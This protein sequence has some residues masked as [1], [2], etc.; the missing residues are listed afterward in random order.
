MGMDVSH[1]MVKRVVPESEIKMQISED[2]WIE[3][4]DG[5]H[6]IDV[7]S[8]TID[9]MNKN[10]F[11]EKDIQVIQEFDWEKWEK[12]NPQYEN[13]EFYDYCVHGNHEHWIQLTSPEGESILLN[14]GF[15]YKN[16][17]YIV[18]ESREIGY[19][20]KPFRHYDEAS[21]KE[22]DAIV[23][24]VTNFSEKGL[25]GYSELKKMDEEQTEKGNVYLFD[26]NQVR[27]LQKYSYDE[28]VYQSNFIE[29]WTDK[30]YINFNW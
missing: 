30:S 23:I 1:Y 8:R 10:S 15:P 7:N 21:Y 13:Y 12:E 18:V 4:P 2:G 17:S 22:G 16:V 28:K 6:K 26:K 3:L 11:D 29:D 14:E 20:R 24:T 27:A 25:D 5:F 9:W 19:M